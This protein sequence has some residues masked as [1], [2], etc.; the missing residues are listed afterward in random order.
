[1]TSNSFQ[2][3][4][5]V[6]LTSVFASPSMFLLLNWIVYSQKQSFEALGT[7]NFFLFSIAFGLVFSLPSWLVFILGVKYLNRLPVTTF[8][9]KAF[10][11]IVAIFLT[12][13]PFYLIFFKDDLEQQLSNFKFATAYCLTI[14][15]GIFVYKLTPDNSI[16]EV[17]V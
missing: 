8:K 7:G 2:F 3:A 5:K 16:R 11:T 1:M 13:L 12:Y 4:T 17:T 9:K 14:I 6:W 10:I 15:I